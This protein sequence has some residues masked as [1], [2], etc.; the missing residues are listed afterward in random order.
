VHRVTGDDGRT[1]A[2]EG[3]RCLPHMFHHTFA[4]KFLTNS[5]DLSTLQKIL[6][7]SS[8]A[9]VRMYLEL[10]PEDIRVQHRQYS[11]VDWIKLC[12]NQR[13]EP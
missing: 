13:A 7:H 2:V 4:K 5:G 11:P 3:V 12:L 9:V 1:A 10:T 6:A 8:L